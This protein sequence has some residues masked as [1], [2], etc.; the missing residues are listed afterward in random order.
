MK[1]S[2]AGKI[3]LFVVLLVSL[4]LLVQGLISGTVTLKA[5]HQ[6]MEAQL[7][8]EASSKAGRLKALV[9]GT[10]EDLAVMRAHRDIENYF[11]SRAFEDLD[12]MTESA[13]RLDL[14]FKR[15]FEA[16]PHYTR[17]Q[18]VAVSGSHDG[19]P[20]LEM[21]S[22]ERVERFSSFKNKDA[23]QFFKSSKTSIFHYFGQDETGILTLF[24]ASVLN[25]E[26]RMEGFLWLA[27]PLDDPL[28][29]VMNE[30]EES[31]IRAVIGQIEGTVVAKTATL[32][33]SDAKALVLGQV[34]DWVVVS[35]PIT[36]LG[37]KLTLA[38]ERDGAHGV[39]YTMFSV[40]LV[41]AL[42][43]MGALGFFIRRVVV[44]RLRTIGQTIHEIA[45]GDLTLRVPVQSNPDEIDVIAQNVNVLADGLTESVRTIGMHTGSVT[46]FIGEILK[47]RTFLGKDSDE[48]YEFSSRIST[49]NQKLSGEISNIR[50]QVTEATGKM[51]GIARDAQEVS[52]SVFTIASAAEEA[53]INVNTMASSAEEMSS[54]V[55]GVNNNL[56]QVQDSLSRV[57]GSMNQINH[58]LEEVRSRCKTA[59]QQSQQA[60]ENA[61]NAAQVMEKLALSAQ[62]IGDVVELINNIAEQTNMLALNASIEAAGA[63]D[64]GKGFAVVANEVKDLARQTGQAT[65]LIYQKIREIQ[66]NTEN[67]NQATQGISTSVGQ[68]N[69]SNQE[70]THSVDEQAVSIQAISDSMKQVSEATE[71]VTRNAGELQF[72][73]AE[74]ARAAVET[75][76][77]ATEIAASSSQVA[78]AA[79]QMSQKSAEA[80]ALAK[81]TLQS[82]ETT[83][84]A[85][86]VV[87]EKVADSLNRVQSM[88]GSVNHFKSLGSVARSIS[89][90]LHTA[91]ST[92][93]VG[94][95]VLDIRYFKEIHL[96]L[97]GR[98]ERKLSSTVTPQEDEMP[99]AS[100]CPMGKWCSEVDVTLQQNPLFADLL[101]THDT[102]HQVATEIVEL[103]ANSNNAEG[104]VAMRYYQTVQSTLFEQLNQLYLGEGSESEHSL[105]V[106]DDAYLIGLEAIDNDHKKLV[107]MMN[108]LY[109]SVRSGE[110][111]SA[112]LGKL[113]TELAEYTQSHFQREE[114]WMLKSN[115]PGYDLHKKQHDGFIEKVGGFQKD[116]QETGFTLSTDVLVFLRNWLVNHIR[117]MDKQFAAHESKL[118]V[119]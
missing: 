88:Q 115:Y 66:E 72:A 29:K 71:E 48:V 24:S 112:H 41:S 15:V 104:Q 86:H 7:R 91:Q 107:N 31:G 106:W 54:N 117:G 90:A 56:T 46:A 103:A 5:M 68:I 70:I 36:V 23:L 6:N 82:A 105:V 10:G 28:Q 58:S 35:Q 13:S 116:F 34:G 57:A 50:N 87:E 37:W 84:S 119:G 4:V 3:L 47:I 63:G 109:L 17:M 100:L 89:D 80:L 114:S 99:K 92:F 32:K 40:G 14:F 8:G 16:K 110:G 79:E 20:V 11:T 96:D 60:G 49:E 25:I 55:N 102:L 95:E 61:R 59:N 9:T 74:V 76:S 81:E 38:L 44:Q 67:A 64:A 77:G 83:Q 12:G 30:L 42:L 18:L 22:G 51:E 39:L 118:T 78:Q 26:N 19:T 69:V 85:S 101:S 33:E 43:L 53:S 45:Q 62:E 27:Q 113:L 111:G 93:Y 1:L 52:E 73:A 75:A 97:L 108:E 65:D 94:A 2:L 98:L 21:D